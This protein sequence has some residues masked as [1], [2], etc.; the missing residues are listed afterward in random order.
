MKITLKI[1][2]G[3]QKGQL[4]HFRQ[5]SSLI[6][7]RSPE[8]QIRLS[9]KDPY[10]SRRHSLIE[11]SPPRCLITN[12][13]GTNKTFL[14]SKEIDSAEIKNGDIIQ[15]GYTQIKVD[16]SQELAIRKI[17]CK[18]CGLVMELL[19]G[20]PDRTVCPACDH[21]TRSKM[22]IPDTQILH[23]KCR[24]GRDLTREA[25]SDGRA[26]ELRGI[27]GYACEFCLPY[28]G[29]EAGQVIGQYHI[30]RQIGKGGMGK[31][32]LVH[33]RPTCRVLVVKRI[34]TLVQEK[35]IKRF[36]REVYLLRELEHPNLIRYVDSSLDEFQPFL[37]MSFA[38]HGNLND[39]VL[40]KAERPISE[41]LALILGSLD[42]LAYIHKKGIVHRDI[43]PENILL[44]KTKQGLVPQITDFGIAKK[45][46]EAGGTMLTN[47][48]FFMGSPFFMPP[49][50]VIS[51]KTVREPGDIFSM[52]VTLYYVLTGRIPFDFPSP[53]EIQ[54]FIRENNLQGISTND[55][56]HQMGYKGNPF[57][58]SLSQEI[59]P[60]RNRNPEIPEKLAA[61]VDK[62]IC[63]KPA[64]RYQT[65]QEFKAA[66]E[67]A[68][69]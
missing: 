11:I 52:G 46:A 27:V 34:T 32:Y 12:L 23:V 66:L 26:M 47:T 36:Q 3:P 18:Q 22:R 28:S 37:V 48:R 38:T 44:Q 4:F 29:P 41:S 30:I 60:I 2:K 31:V 24:C 9:N 13:S 8:A 20:E 62:S 6:I 7:G 45:Y 14:N 53:K 25:N 35:Q 51:F 42:G 57:L 39:Y 1:I 64:E 50:Q 10:I 67:E 55:V 17:Q 40:K 59:I 43:K 65:A 16:I 68:V 54:D 63:K 21:R 19:P 58:V 5:P 33:H 49:E 56:I 15:V 61:V 69:R